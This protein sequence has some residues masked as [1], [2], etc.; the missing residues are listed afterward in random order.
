ME[1]IL[2]DSRRNLAGIVAI[3]T[4]L[5]CLGFLWKSNVRAESSRIINGSNVTFFYQITAPGES[6]IEL[7]KI[8]QF[9][10]GRHQLPPALER[11]V[12]G[13]K[14]GDKK[15]VE[16]SAAEGFGPHDAKKQTTVPKRDLP[17][18]TK[19]GDILEDRSGRE[20]TVAR[21]SERSAVMDYNHP[22]AGKPLRMK[23]TILR[24]DDP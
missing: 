24:V 8:G 12:I 2:G 11:A 16:L 3:V 7:R 22:L 18:G 4:G 1:G 21:L 15:S 10:Q 9:I 5:A 13:M 14:A 6:G 23:I 19:V 17:I 20:A